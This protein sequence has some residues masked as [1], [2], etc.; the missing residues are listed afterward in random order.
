MIALIDADMLT[1]RIGWACNEETE[2]TAASA[3]RSFVSQILVNLKEVDWQDY[4]LF[5]SGSTN[6][7]KD[8]AVTAPYKGN[9]K[10]LEKPVHYAFLRDTM[11]NEYEADL[12]VD[13]EAD[14]TIMKRF[15]ELNGEGIISSLDKDFDQGAGWHHNFAK[16]EIYYVTEEEALFNFYSQF[17]EGDRIDNII[18]VRGIGKVKARKLLEGKTAKEMFE[19]CGDKLGSYERALENGRLLYLRRYDN[20]IWESP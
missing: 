19:I 3:L 10:D 9:R 4:E 1:Y 13:E 14:D 17:L 5:L 18:G 20:E 6:F 11:L 2:K 16:N 15:T 8:I 7:R 12:S